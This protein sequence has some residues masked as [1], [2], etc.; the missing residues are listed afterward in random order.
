[1]NYQLHF[2]RLALLAPF[3]VG[4][5]SAVLLIA[6]LAPAA[7]QS[8]LNPSAAD[9]G[10][11]VT[12]I[13]AS[14][15]FSAKELAAPPVNNWV[16]NGGALN[17]QNYSPLKQINR[18]N[19]GM[20]KAVWQTHLE[21]SGLANK[22]SGEGQPVVYQGVVYIVTGADD[23]FAISVKTGEIAWKYKANLDQT[24]TGVCCG[25]DSRGLADGRRQDLCRTT[26]RA[27]GRARSEDRS[28]EMVHPSGALAGGILY[29]GS[30]TVLRRN[31][32]GGV[33][34]RRKRHPRPPQGLRRKGWPSAVDVLHG[35][36]AG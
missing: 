17:N 11:G 34:G 6:P 29:Y 3:S 14:P 4:L 5:A 30:S 10:R 22:Y 33:F 15:E 23:V 32:D 25:W 9:G 36:R 20:L 26:G 13:A 28:T 8:A 24:I 16:K 31:G 19:V 21:G 27:L 18:E 7:P 35:P 1:M 2:R 12:S